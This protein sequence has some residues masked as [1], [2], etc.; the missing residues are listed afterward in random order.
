MWIFCVCPSA[1]SFPNHF[2]TQLFRYPC[3]A[4]YSLYYLWWVARV[5]LRRWLRGVRYTAC[6]FK[7]VLSPWP[8]LRLHLPDSR[9][10]EGS[11][12]IENAGHICL[13]GIR[14]FLKYTYI[15]IQLP[16]R[17]RRR[18]GYKTRLRVSC[19]LSFFNQ[20]FLSASIPASFLFYLVSKGPAW[21]LSHL[22]CLLHKQ[23]LG[24]NILT[25][26]FSHPETPSV[27]ER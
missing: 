11:P 20:A 26:F 4:Q 7:V 17:S 12:R 9:A 25:F 8:S 24:S 18:W 1:S 13:S 27:G 14:L 16:R 21:L 2:F 19:C 3:T 22:W 6:C 5:F 15:Y 23:H 10:E